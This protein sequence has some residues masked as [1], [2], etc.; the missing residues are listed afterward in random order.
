MRKQIIGFIAR[1][2]ILIVGI[3]LYCKFSHEERSLTVV[4]AILLIFAGAVVTF[5]YILKSRFPKLSIA[6][7]VVLGILVIWLSDLACY[8]GIVSSMKAKL[9]SSSPSVTTAI[10]EIS[11]QQGFK[12]GKRNRRDKTKDRWIYYYSISVG[13]K[14]YPGATVSRYKTFRVGDSVVVR[15][16]PNA[17]RISKIALPASR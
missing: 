17:P 3:W 2:A 15:Y 11:Y 9:N 14:T 4:F 13:G 7:G 1:L 8:G 10:D 16:N 6:A 12:G 5:L